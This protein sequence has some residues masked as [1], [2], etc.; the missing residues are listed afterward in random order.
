MELH[1]LKFA[2]IIILR[3]DIAEVI[4]DD[5]VV[6]TLGMVNEYHEFLIKHLQTPFSLLI[7]K[8]NEYSY[9]FQAQLLIGNIPEIHAMAV[10]SYTRKS[11]I[12]THLLANT[13]PRTKVWNLSV[14]N[15]REIA[16]EWLE[17]QQD[18]VSRLKDLESS[19]V[20]TGGIY[21]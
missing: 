16:L 17:E 18:V 1:V 4:I 9:E 5:N 6:M 19:N 20:E 12:T 15:Q 14:F 11:A 10:V 8:I 7:N 21:E 3:P 2:K 13:T